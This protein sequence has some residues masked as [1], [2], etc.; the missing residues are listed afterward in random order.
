MKLDLLCYLS[1]A[2]GM[3]SHFSNAFILN[4]TSK[5]RSS[6][7]HD[8]RGYEVENID[9]KRPSNMNEVASRIR[10]VNYFISRECNYNC[11]F[12]F[13]T[14]KNTDKLS[15]EKSKRGL[16]M[17]K[18]EGCEKINFAGGEPFLNDMLLGELCRHCSNDLGMAVSIISNG[19]LIKPYWMQLFGEYV[20]VLGVSIDSVQAST[21][22]AIGRGGDANNKHVERILK[23]RELCS[24]H[25]ITFKMNTVV[26][27]LNWR[28]DMSDFVRDLDPKRWKVF[29]VLILKNENSGGPGELRDARN[30]QVTSDQFT[31][32]VKRHDEF[33]DVLVPEPNNVMQNSYLLLD[34]KLRF[35][36]C[37]NG[38]KIPSD[39]IL[40]VGI[41]AALH[42]AGFDNDA[43]HK[44]GGIYDWTRVRDK[45]TKA[46]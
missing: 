45:T 13:H 5:R 25:D 9:T 30:L 22:A 16:E 3:S 38:G 28:E 24:K 33:K 42:Q 4:S 23:V 1:L 7:C 8:G 19:S 37:S 2:V 6:R 31:S 11:Q 34:E 29:Q 18:A 21:N 36:D 27:S 32:F 10:S 15:L 46:P 12:C 35:L 40:D 26:C 20:D 41:E 39:S 14:Q 17:L 43:F 44:R